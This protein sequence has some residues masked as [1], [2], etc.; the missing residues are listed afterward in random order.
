MRK[1]SAYVAAGCLGIALFAVACGAQDKSKRPV[2]R[3][4]PALTLA[5][6]K[7]PLI[8]PVRA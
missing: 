4:P 5:A 1:V 3:P 8:I 6:Q 2:R 7:S